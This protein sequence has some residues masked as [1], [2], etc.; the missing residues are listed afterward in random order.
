MEVLQLPAVTVVPLFIGQER[1]GLRFVVNPDIIQLIRTIRGIRWSGEFSCWHLPLTKEHY[2]LLKNT[3]SGKFRIDDSYLK[4]YLR[5]R[6]LYVSSKNEMH[7]SFRRFELIR[8]YPLCVEN[9]QAFQ[10]Y[11]A[12]LRLKGYSPNT[13]RNYCQEFHLLLRLLKEHPVSGLNREQVLSYLLWLIRKR[14]YKESHTHMAVNALKFYFEQVEGRAKEFYSIPR[15]VRPSLLPDI[16]SGH[17]ISRLLEEI[18]NVKHRAMVMGA[19]ASGL[20][21]SELVGLQVRDIDSKRMMIHIRG[22]K[23]KKDRMVPLSVIFLTTLREYYRQYKPVIFLFEGSKGQAYSA[24]SVQ[25]IL[26]KAKDRSKILK[27][28]SVHM[29]R[30]SYATHLLEG[31]TDIRYIQE[32][33]GHNSVGTT[34]RY[35]HVSVKDIGRI[36]S[37]LDKLTFQIGRFPDSKNDE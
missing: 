3:S 29:L 20:R 11:L 33:L 4:E 22:G 28:G 37:P 32:L 36:I 17:E 5:Q 12:L 8:Q 7:I 21:V 35:T 13:I 34:M 15:P 1:L 2:R 6:K 26:Q 23:G 27:K 10:D 31:G 9:L 19:Y 30:H 25:K 24:R 14:G 18:K 16:L